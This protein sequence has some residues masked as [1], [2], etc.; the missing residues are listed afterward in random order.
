[1]VLQYGVDV[2]NIWLLNWKIFKVG[3]WTSSV[4]M[5]LEKRILRT[6]YCAAHFNIN[7][8][9]NKTL[10]RNELCS[11]FAASA[12]PVAITLAEIQDATYPTL[13]QPL[14]KLAE[15]IRSQQWHWVLN[16][17]SPSNDAKSFDCKIS[18]LSTKFVLR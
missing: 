3:V 2:R 11:P 17:S 4:V 14:Q 6:A 10:Q 15:L 13:I 1:M 7:L 5:S 9:A 18:K 12:V 16:S 8:Y